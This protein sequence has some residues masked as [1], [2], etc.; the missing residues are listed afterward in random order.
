M[1]PSQENP[2]PLYKA[3]L[4]ALEGCL[5]RS[6]NEL[7]RNS[8]NEFK[9]NRKTAELVLWWSIYLSHLRNFLENKNTRSL[10]PW[11]YLTSFLSG[12]LLGLIQRLDLSGLL[13]NLLGILVVVLVCTTIV[14][15]FYELDR[16]QFISRLNT[17]EKEI[18]HL[19]FRLHP[20]SDSIQKYEKIIFELLFDSD[21]MR[22]ISRSLEYSSMIQL[23][24]W[25]SLHK[26]SFIK[27]VVLKNPEK[28]RA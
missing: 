18:A 20:E 4:L 1:K 27:R 7:P 24:G 19:G 28:E 16:I 10:I 8:L 9:R 11:L 23:Y 2:Y 26:V 13:L 3:Q 22:M 25:E 12:A 14:L 5:A 21:P 6:A 15:Y 17:L